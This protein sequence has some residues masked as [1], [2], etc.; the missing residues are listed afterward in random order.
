MGVSV[1]VPS[2]ARLLLP[3]LQVAFILGGNATFTLRSQKT[4]SRFTYNVTRVCCFNC[5]RDF[6]GRKAES[7]KTC[8]CH[9]GANSY[10]VSLLSG[11]DNERDYTYLGMLVPAVR[12]S[13][14]GPGTETWKFIRTARSRVGDEAPS[15]R[16]FTWTIGRLMVGVEPDGVEIWHAGKCGI[17][18][19]KLTVPSSIAIGIGPDCLEGM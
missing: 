2:E 5:K 12:D 11:S 6:T 3:K 13:E 19:R 1:A 16:A 10:F 4:G 7:C 15:Y 9:L 14:T 17:C 8:R 18:G